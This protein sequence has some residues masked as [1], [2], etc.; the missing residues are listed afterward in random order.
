MER[1]P[2]RQN[3]KIKDPVTRWYLL[4]QCLGSGSLGTVFLGWEK[5]TRSPVVIRKIKR[6]CGTFID[7]SSVLMK[8]LNKVFT[9]ALSNFTELLYKRILCLVDKTPPREHPE[10]QVRD[11]IGGKRY[12]N[13]DEHLSFI[14]VTPPTFINERM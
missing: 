14:I 6:R 9:H 10:I 7:E 2:W 8:E 3:I 4:G 12:F 11:N 1:S 5:R 13:C